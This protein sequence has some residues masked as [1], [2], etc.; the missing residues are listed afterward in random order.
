MIR[1]NPGPLSWT[2]MRMVVSSKP[3]SRSRYPRPDGTPYRS[4]LVAS[5]LT[6]SN[7]SSRRSCTPHARKV[8][9]VN[10]PRSCDG[11]GRAQVETLAH[12]R[13]LNSWIHRTIVA[14]RD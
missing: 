12:E 14:L 9:R 2:S 8:S 1:E 6:Q 4:A 3:N 11:S 7:M 5:S 13:R 10:C